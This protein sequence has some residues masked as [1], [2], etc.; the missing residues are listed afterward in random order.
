MSRAIEGGAKVAWVGYFRPMDNGNEFS[1]CIDEL[2]VFR[3]RMA[4]L[5]A[6]ESDMVF[7]DGVEHG[8]GVEEELY[9]EDGYHPSVEGSALMGEVVAET[10]AEEFGF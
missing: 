1:G 3:S 10:V 6:N 4:R 8:S 5:D 9:A 7:I 2:E